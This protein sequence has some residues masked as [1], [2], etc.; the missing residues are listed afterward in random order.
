MRREESKNMAATIALTNAKKTQ[1]LMMKL[2][3]NAMVI[4]TKATIAA[5]TP[6]L[7]LSAALIGVNYHQKQQEN[8]M[9]K[10]NDRMLEYESTIDRLGQSTKVLA[11]EELAKALGAG[12]I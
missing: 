11:D 1:T 10:A 6:M 12:A 8:I 5:V 2:N 7:L 3:S 4:S 9:N